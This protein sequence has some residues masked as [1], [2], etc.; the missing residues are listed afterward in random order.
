MKSDSKIRP[1]L[2]SVLSQ[3]NT[4]KTT[5]P[6]EMQTALNELNDAALH[7]GAKIFQLNKLEEAERFLNIAAA[8][9]NA[10]SQFALATCG[11]YRDGIWHHKNGEVTS[12][13]SDDTKKWLRLAAAQNYI[14]ALIQLGDAQSLEKA[15]GLLTNPASQENPQGMYYMYLITNDTHWLEKSA[16]VG[17]NQAQY[18]LAQLYQQKPEIFSNDTLRHARIEELLQASADGGL[19]LAVY[20]R[21]FSDESNASF[22][23]K[24]SRLAQLAWM[25]Q[26]YGM[27]EYGYA[28]A[29]F[30]RAQ[31]DA[32]RYAPG[33]RQAPRTYGLAKD[34]GLAYAMLK[35]VLKKTAEVDEVPMLASDLHAIEM[36]MTQTDWEKART[37]LTELADKAIEPFSRLEE[38]IIPGTAK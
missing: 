19:P 28:L 37:T 10:W 8:N 22:A 4:Q 24:Q 23:E 21:V 17:W 9:G 25:G 36:Q 16:A 14:P 30:A 7:T 18:K 31:K 32:S 33:E 2:F 13:A 26:V 1:A 35:Y 5:M 6:L 27:L 20:A 34:L 12:H 3:L 15:K 29:N 11:A 38:L